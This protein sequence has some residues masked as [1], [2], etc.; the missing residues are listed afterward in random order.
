MR[1]VDAPAALEQA[2]HAAQAEAEACFQNRDMYLEKLIEHPRH[3]EVQIL[4]DTHGNTVYLGERDCSIQRRRQKLLEEAPAWGLSPA[5][6]RSLGAWAVSLAKKAG[7]VGAG[8]VEFVLAPDG[9]FYFIEMNTRIQVEHPVTEMITGIDLV[10]EQLRIAAGLPLSFSQEDIRFQGHAIECRINAESPRDHFRP[11]PG[12]TAFLHLPG[13]PF[14]RVDTA[15]Y[16]GC[17]VS[18]HYDSLVAKVIT[19][20]K[21]RLEAIRRMRRALEELIIEGYDT[22]AS[23]SHLILFEPTFVRGRYDTG[24]IAQHLEKLL[25]LISTCEVLT[26]DAERNHFEST[27]YPEKR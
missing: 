4:S 6:R 27:I 25:Q 18:P 2:F 17:D 26:A 10:K 5:Q 11:C 9:S 3:I 23:L 16:T 22:N 12:V 21:T 1:Q 15:L 7:Y 24:F 19:H 8:T 14:V 20:G 13:G